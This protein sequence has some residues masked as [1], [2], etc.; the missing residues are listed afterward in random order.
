VIL[1]KTAKHLSADEIKSL[2]QPLIRKS[3]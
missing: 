1:A 3:Q 2:T